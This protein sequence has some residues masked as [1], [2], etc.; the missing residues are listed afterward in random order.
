MSPP[1]TP[2]SRERPLVLFLRCLAVLD[3]CAVGVACLPDAVID[4]LHQ[5]TGLGPFPSHSTA[6]YLARITGALYGVH[7]ALLW[8]LSTDVRR[9]APLIAWLARLMIA[10]GLVLLVIDLTH[11][12]PWWWTLLEGPLLAG[13]GARL[14][15]W[16]RRAATT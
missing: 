14:L 4:H 16:A 8:G 10:H 11:A 13:L 3:L 9:Y 5:A 12:R 15:G 1:A 2:A 7:G 6:H